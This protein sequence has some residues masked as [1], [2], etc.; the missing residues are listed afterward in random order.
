MINGDL[1]A[2]LKNYQRAVDIAVANKDSNLKLFQKNLGI[3][4]QKLKYE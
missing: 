3:I 2:S 1:E 4:K